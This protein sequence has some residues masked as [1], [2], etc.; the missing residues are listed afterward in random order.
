M[1]T[2]DGRGFLTILGPSAAAQFGAKVAVRQHGEVQ[3]QEIISDIKKVHIW[4]ELET[5]N[6]LLLSEYGPGDLQSY[7]MEGLNI[8]LGE[9]F[10]KGSGVIKSIHCTD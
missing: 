7:S 6:I 4:T 1:P 2:A 5:A 8:I 3:Q 10:V 9:E